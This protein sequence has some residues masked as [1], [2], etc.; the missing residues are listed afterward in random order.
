MLAAQSLSI[1][2]RNLM[3]SWSNN[4]T[5]WR[6]KQGKT[7][8]LSK[9][10]VTIRRPLMISSLISV[11]L[12]L[13][14]PIR[15]ESWRR[16]ET[17]KCPLAATLM[18]NASNINT[19]ISP[20]ITMRRAH[21]SPTNKKSSSDWLARHHPLRLDTRNPKLPASSHPRE[22]VRIQT[23]SQWDR[24]EVVGL[25]RELDSPQATDEQAVRL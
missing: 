22:Q 13:A 23:M 10:L 3:M 16:I 1:Q 9:R 25:Q 4:G 5:L 15:L 17:N 19:K 18:W 6:K 2:S 21:L 7:C 8:L 14:R 24:K 20:Q 11:H 12:R